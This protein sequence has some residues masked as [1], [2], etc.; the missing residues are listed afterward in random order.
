M[1][2]AA[3]DNAALPY[4]PE[5]LWNEV[6]DRREN[7]RGIQFHRREFVGTPTPKSTEGESQFLRLFIARARESIDLTVLVARNLRDDMCRGA[8]AVDSQ[9]FTIA[10]LD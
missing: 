2:A 10:R 8:K 1:D 5:S 4:S 3:H 9:T 6:A 7:N